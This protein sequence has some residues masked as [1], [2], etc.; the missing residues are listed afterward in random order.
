MIGCQ[1]NSNP[2]VDFIASQ[3]SSGPDIKLSTD[4]KD[5]PVVV[6]MWATWCGPCKQFRPS[7]NKMAEKYKS[8]GIAFLA[9]SGE[10]KKLIEQAEKKEPH[11]M[12]VLVDSFGSAAQEVNADALPTIIIL[13]K[14]HRPVWGSKGING[15]TESEMTT[16]LDALS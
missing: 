5:K 6:Y 11:A 9:I 14:Q 3:L 15:S 4:Y 13:D 10:S 8:K 2:K 16:T 1:S 12:T 7:L